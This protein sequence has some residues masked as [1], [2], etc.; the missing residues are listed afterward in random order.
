MEGLLNRPDMVFLYDANEIERLFKQE[1]KMPHR[2]SMPSLL[3]YKQVLR[4]DYFE[5][6]PGVIGVYVYLN[7]FY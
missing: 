4:K 5:N 7:H 6:T 1:E 2:P 3:Y